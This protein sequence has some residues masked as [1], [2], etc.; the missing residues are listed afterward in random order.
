MIKMW[1]F[2]AAG[3]A[4]IIS[5]AADAQTTPQECSTVV[6]SLQRL[7]CFDKLFPTSEAGEQKSDA[8]EGESDLSKWEITEEKS[9][10][11]ESPRITAFIVPKST[12]G[13]K[14]LL[15]EPSIGLRCYDKKTSVIYLHNQFGINEQTGVTY[16]I[17]SEPART[18]KWGRSDNYRAVGLWSGNKAIPFI[19]KLKNGET[20]AIQ[21]DNPRSEAVFDLGN[22]EEVATKLAA[23]CNWK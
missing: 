16:R 6:D 14:S 10:I 3:I 8:T 7:T 1:G 5:G 18:E 2:I 21:T 22:V 11:D 19:K 12:G 4:L 23:A 13:G 9:P 20:L 15:G 17:G